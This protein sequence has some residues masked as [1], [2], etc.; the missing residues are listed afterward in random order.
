VGI[1]LHPLNGEIYACSGVATEL[2]HIDPVTG[3]V[4]KIGTGMGHEKTDC[5]NLGAPWKNVIK[6]Q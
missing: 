1:E 3:T 4:T 6:K 2:L 5:D